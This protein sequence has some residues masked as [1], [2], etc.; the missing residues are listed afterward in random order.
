MSEYDPVKPPPEVQN[1]D[2]GA[3]PPY[4][5]KE[6]WWRKHN[7]TS[8]NCCMECVCRTVCLPYCLGTCV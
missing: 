2:L 4:D 7:D 3:P 1:M 6:P 5:F 8:A